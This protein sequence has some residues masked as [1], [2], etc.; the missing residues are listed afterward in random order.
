MTAV[1][2]LSILVIIIIL[3]IIMLFYNS[4]NLKASSRKLSFILQ[5]FG[6][7]CIAGL[8]IIIIP[9]VIYFAM[10]K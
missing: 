5:I 4:K 8:I 3:L 6:Y 2:S 10:Y 9:A 7:I 1:F